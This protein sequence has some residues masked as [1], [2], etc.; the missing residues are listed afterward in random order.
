VRAG[1][2]L[3]EIMG[4]IVMVAIL[5]GF[6]Y[7][8]YYNHIPQ[9]Q[10]DRAVHDLTTLAQAL[11]TYA[12]DNADTLTTTSPITLSDLRGRYIDD[13]PPDPWGSE[14]TVDP[15]FQRIVSRGPNGKLETLVPALRAS[16]ESPEATAE[17]SDDY[18]R[19]WGVYGTIAFVSGG[20]LYTM[21]PDGSRVIPVTGN[22]SEGDS[23]SLSPDRSRFLI[24]R[25]GKLSVL[26]LGR[27]AQWENEMVYQ[28]Q[29]LSGSDPAWSEDGVKFAYVGSAGFGSGRAIDVS[30]VTTVTSAG[31]DKIA[32]AGPVVV[33][34]SGEP[35]SPTLSRDNRDISFVT[36][37]G[38]LMR[39]AS[40]P[41]SPLTTMNVKDD[42]L[43]FDAT[44][45]LKD[46]TRVRWS[47]DGKHL[48]YV[49][50]DG[51]WL[52]S[53]YG[54]YPGASATD[55]GRLQ[56]T[57]GSYRDIAWSPDG[58]RLALAQDTKIYVTPAQR[59]VVSPFPLKVY[60]GSSGVTALSW[61]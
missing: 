59:G 43:P 31:D 56:V 35:T 47:P 15:F 49:G 39:A 28:G 37:D 10:T 2:S 12:R 27:D 38:D 20:S 32:A 57:A 22:M 8:I 30:E 11:A 1:L 18:A 16:G 53:I 21:R 51:V 17:G 40:T 46:A 7:G 26:T 42:G 55:R 50:A 25:A 19:T 58:T 44:K 34:T 54:S 61:R 60:E 29:A 4:A 33:T 45:R 24:S 5:T 23:A 48:A 13:V 52:R 41:D 6:A 3:L 36:R 9:A 14:Y